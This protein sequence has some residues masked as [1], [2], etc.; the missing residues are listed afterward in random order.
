MIGKPGIATNVTVCARYEYSPYGEL[1]T[2]STGSY[3]GLANPFR[4]STKYYDD[5]TGFYYFG[6]RY[7]NPETGRW[8]NR[9]P[10][11]ERGG[12][13]LYGYVNN[14]PLSFVDLYGLRDVDLVIYVKKENVPND[15]K[16]N[17]V[18]KNLQEQWEKCFSTLKEDKV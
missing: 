10:I 13:N 3:A 15:F 14:N 7:Y 18:E 17:E 12:L 16:I 6:Y 1:L 5:E 9:D 2:S 11:E 4:S 8:L